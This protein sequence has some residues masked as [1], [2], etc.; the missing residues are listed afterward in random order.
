MMTTEEK[1]AEDEMKRVRRKI[2]FECEL[3][4]ITSSGGENGSITKSNGVKSRERYF[5]RRP[6]R[7][8]KQ[9]QRMAEQ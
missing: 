9:Q 5:I 6:Q 3:I 1:K 2:I 8:G 4:E 7:Y